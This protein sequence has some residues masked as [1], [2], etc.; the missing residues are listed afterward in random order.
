[1]CSNDQA[2]DVLLWSVHEGSMYE[3]LAWCTNGIVLYGPVDIQWTV[4]VQ[5]GVHQESM[6]KKVTRGV[7]F[8]RAVFLPRAKRLCRGV[9]DRRSA[10]PQ[11]M[12]VS[13]EEGF[14]SSTTTRAR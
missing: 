13:G 5:T 11:S 12:H 14:V 4:C 2:N 7:L 6:S 1:M 10:D 8:C 3:R 9:H